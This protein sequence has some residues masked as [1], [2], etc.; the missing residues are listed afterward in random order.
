MGRRKKLEYIIY[1]SPEDLSRYFPYGKS[2]GPVCQK[3]ESRFTAGPNPMDSW[4][5]GSAEDS[6]LIDVMVFFTRTYYDILFSD[7]PKAQVH[8][9]VVKALRANKTSMAEFIEMCLDNEYFQ[10]ILDREYNYRVKKPGGYEENGA[11]FR[12][13]IRSLIP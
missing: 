11:K 13:R 10:G 2:K 9:T 8:H 3:P 12:E 7:Y 4:L 6:A 5:S 1:R